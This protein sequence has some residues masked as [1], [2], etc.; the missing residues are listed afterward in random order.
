MTGF[1][2]TICELQGKKLNIEVKSLNSKQL[3]IYTRIPHIY[4]EK[5]LE[6]RNLLKQKLDRG[7]VEF[8]IYIDRIEDEKTAIINKSVI[9]NYYRQLKEITGELNI[10]QSEQLL[11]AI[12]KLPDTVKSEYDK[13]DEEEWEKVILCIRDAIIE[14]ISFR[15]HE[16]KALE[17]DIIERVKMIESYLQQVEPLE[18]GRI[19][20]VR[21]RLNNNLH[22]FV[23]A[24]NFDTNRLEQEIIFYLEK[25]D[26]TEEKVRLKT[27]CEYFLENVSK[28]SP[29]GKKLGFISQEMGREINTLGAK[30]NDTGIQK[31]VIQ[32][33]DELEKIK[34]QLL[35]VL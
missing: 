6:I 3:D 21:Q 24:D 34:E 15:T 28:G 31:L 8:G 32:M 2:K 9:I 33:K 27:H 29:I 18:K 10:E 25:L 20:N 22:E 7:K 26:I 16:G 19:N 14:L 12:M 13:L 4:K 11:P 1:G 35:N 23:S 5:E 17:K 30:A